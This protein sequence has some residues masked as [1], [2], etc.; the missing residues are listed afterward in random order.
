MI[1]VQFSHEKEQYV[2]N[3]LYSRCLRLF[4]E[5]SRQLAIFPAGQNGENV[6]S[7]EY[8]I[9]KVQFTI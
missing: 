4:G 1:V 7:K 6:T 3:C 5:L 8:N 2:I 9:Q